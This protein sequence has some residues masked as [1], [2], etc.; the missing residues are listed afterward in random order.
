[1]QLMP[2]MSPQLATAAFASTLSL[3]ALALSAPGL[4]DARATGSGLLPANA[5]MPT[6]QFPALPAILPR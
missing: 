1:M 2:K 3:D 5:H 6:A 4:G